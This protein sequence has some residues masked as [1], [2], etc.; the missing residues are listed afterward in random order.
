ME[1]IGVVKKVMIEETREDGSKGR[2]DT[3]HIVHLRN[4]YP[5]CRVILSV[6][7]YSLQASIR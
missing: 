5:V 3:N 4:V 6:H 1:Y 7:G 2:T